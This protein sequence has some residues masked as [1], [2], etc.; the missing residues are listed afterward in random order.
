[1]VQDHLKPVFQKIGV[2]SRRELLARFRA[3]GEE[4]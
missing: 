1:M 2:H 3:S 4:G